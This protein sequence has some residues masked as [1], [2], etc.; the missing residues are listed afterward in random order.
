[1]D[2]IRAFFRKET[3]VLVIHPDTVSGQQRAVQHSQFVQILGRGFAAALNASVPVFL[4]FA[5]M[6]MNGHVQPAR[7]FHRA[8]HH[9]SSSGSFA[10]GRQIDMDAVIGCAV[11]LFRESDSRQ[12]IRAA[13]IKIH[14]TV[15]QHGPHSAFLNAFRHT[16]HTEI[17]I[18]EGSG[19]IAQH[20]QCAKVCPG[21]HG[22]V[23]QELFQ[24]PDRLLQPAVQRQVGPDAAEQRHGRMGVQITQSGHGQ[25]A[26]AVDHLFRLKSRSLVP[27]S[28]VNDTVSVD[29]N[30]RI[31]NKRNFFITGH[32]AG[33]HPDM[34][35][36]GPHERSSS[37]AQIREYT[38][39][40]P[41]S[42]HP[43]PN[44]RRRNPR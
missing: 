19:A 38:A 3:N 40:S 37:F 7:F 14:H 30:F 28:G 13:F 21:P 36:S 43:V 6:D 31:L 32:N 25:C 1:M 39:S 42:R 11:P 24:R 5:D 16:I 18:V 41:W 26:F 10:V 4:G 9:L 17:H 29:Q 22:V 15:T 33:R 20:F 23:R 27:L 44:A 2:D 8:L 34:S 35:D 12:Q